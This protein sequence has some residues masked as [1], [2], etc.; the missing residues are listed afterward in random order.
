MRRKLRFTQRHRVSASFF[1][2]LDSVTEVN[3]RPRSQIGQ[4]KG[5]PAIPSVVRAEYGKQRLILIDWQKLAIAKCPAFWWEVE[6][7]NF[8]LAE[9]W[10]R[11]SALQSVLISWKIASY[12]T[13]D[14]SLPTGTRKMSNW[15]RPAR[16]R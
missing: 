3:G 11:H 1:S 15:S 6:T 14:S 9:K 10:D 5:Y 2:E 13:L 12:R 8:Y 16:D 4:C 7:D